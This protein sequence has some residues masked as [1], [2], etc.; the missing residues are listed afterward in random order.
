MKKESTLNRL[1]LTLFFISLPTIALVAILHFWHFLGIFGAQ[2]T[3]AQIAIIL[4]SPM[5][6]LPI[7]GGIASIILV[8]KC[9][10]QYI[11]ILTLIEYP[12]YIASLF[13]FE[14][15]KALGFML[16]QLF[17]TH[18]TQ[19]SCIFYALSLILIIVKF[20]LQIIISFDTTKKEKIDTI[21]KQ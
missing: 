11:Y 1:Q 13:Y 12:L 16:G 10:I 3:P 21:Q 2:G 7:I 18:F 8:C 15:Y 4:F 14:N 5:Y 17:Y 19:W 20:I 9:K 6:L